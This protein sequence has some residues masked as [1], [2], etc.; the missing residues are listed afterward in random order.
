MNIRIG[1]FHSSWLCVFLSVFFASCIAPDVTKR[2]KVRTSLKSSVDTSQP[3]NVHFRK[4]RNTG[5]SWHAI[6]YVNN[7]SIGVASTR[8]VLSWYVPPGRNIIQVFPG[9]RIDCFSLNF[10]CQDGQ[11]GLYKHSEDL[12][13]N[14]FPKPVWVD[15]R[16]GEKN[17]FVLK[18]LGNRNYRLFHSICPSG[19]G[20]VKPQLCRGMD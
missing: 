9:Q 14:R 13:K 6:V 19:P 7:E 8:G 11:E 5:D 17:V 4:D 10:S 1:K 12:P 3:P 18:N 16:D 15:I 20:E 2:R